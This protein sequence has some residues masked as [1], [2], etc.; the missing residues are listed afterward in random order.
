MDKVALDQA[1]ATLRENAEGWARRPLQRKIAHVEQL[2]AGTQA[3]AARQVAAAGYAKGAERDQHRGEEWIHGPLLVTR[4]LRMLRRALREIATHGR[5]QLPKG[6]VTTRG[7]GQV[8]ARIFPLELFD[9]LLYGGFTADVWMQ[10]DV[11]VSSLSQSMASFYRDPNPQGRVALVLGAGNGPSI[12]PLDAVYKLFVEGQVVLLKMNPVN[13]YLAPFIEEAFAP[14]VQAGYLRVVCGGA[15][16]GAYLCQ[17][18]GIDEVHI[19]GSDRTHDAIVFGVGK[20]GEKRKRE[21]RPLLDKRITSE[22]GNVSP[23]I[24]VPG[25]WTA[26]ELRFQ[27]E[28]VATQMSDNAGFNCNATKLLVTHRDWPQRRAFLDELRAVLLTVPP[29][30]AYYPGA[31]DRW[32]SFVGSHAQA[33]TFGQRSGGRLPWA[34]IP[35]LDPTVADEQCFN[36]ESFCGVTGETSLPGADAADFLRRAVDFAN[37]TLWGT[38]N[39]SILIDPRT[40]KAH[41]EALEDAIAGLRYGTVAVNHWAALCYGLGS[42]PWGAFPGHTLDDIKS[43]IGVVHNTFMFEKS[44]KTVIRGPFRIF[45]KPPWFVTNRATD[46]IAPLLVRFEADP[47]LAKLPGVLLAALRG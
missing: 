1:I 11:T 41:A 47:S 36:A 42:P 34:L 15:D 46:R 32:D 28:N 5:P 12:G 9:K 7:D 8:V 10:P 43:G 4:N 6:S 3:V 25:Q 31:E 19:T 14:L 29:R 30:K 45:P 39:A 23:V 35:G 37:G 17:H 44:E 16:V 26:A 27:A 38:L 18:E 20:D 22:L 2:I 24:I 33:E 21:N 13:E 40:H